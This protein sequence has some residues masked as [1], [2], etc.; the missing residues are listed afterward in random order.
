MTV[1]MRF[2][3][4]LSRSLNLALSMMQLF[5]KASYHSLQ[6]LLFQKRGA[7]PQR[8]HYWWLQK[9]S[10]SLDYDLN[11]YQLFPQ[12]PQSRSILPTSLPFT[13]RWKWRKERNSGSPAIP[14]SSWS[15]TLSGILSKLSS[16]RRFH[17]HYAQKLSA[18]PSMTL[19]G[20]SHATRAPICSFRLRM[21]TNSCWHTHWNKRNPLSVSRLRWSLPR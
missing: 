6:H 10:K 17:K 9:A 13:Q 19:L 20:L 18:T 5:K 4:P 7:D 14:F 11:I 8:N 3:S 2:Q 21:T 16:L 1:W 15:P 12:S